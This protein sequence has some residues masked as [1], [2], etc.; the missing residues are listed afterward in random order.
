MENTEK[1][2]LKKICIGE[3]EVLSSGALIVPMSNAIEF[4][5]DNLMFKIVFET[6][7]DDNGNYTQG[8]Y[9][10]DVEKDEASS[11][12]FMKITM[13]NQN[14]AFFSSS[15]SMIHV[16]TLNYRKLF[17]KFC[18]NSINMQDEKETEDKIFYYTWFLEKSTDLAK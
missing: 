5:F 2:I 13:Y 11:S 16:A 9:A 1:S 7:K 15:N 8:R 18:V 17:L 14:K 12:E 3:Y 6:E 10:L 4:M